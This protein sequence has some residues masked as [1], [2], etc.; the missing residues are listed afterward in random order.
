MCW[1][2]G[3]YLREDNVNSINVR[4]LIDLPFQRSFCADHLVLVLTQMF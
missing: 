1:G 2:L 4:K 3:E